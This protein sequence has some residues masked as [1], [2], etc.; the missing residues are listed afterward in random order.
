VHQAHA[1]RLGDALHSAL[2]QPSGAEQ[3]ALCIEATATRLWLFFC[4]N[5]A[6]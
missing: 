6:R 5:T 1:T 4:P 3:S 2:W